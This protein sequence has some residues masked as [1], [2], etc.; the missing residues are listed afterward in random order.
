[1][2]IQWTGRYG[3][4]AEQ[5]AIWRAEKSQKR[6]DKK[7]PVPRRETGAA[8]QGSQ[9]RR[10]G[11]EGAGRRPHACTNAN[12]KQRVLHVGQMPKL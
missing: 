7:C 1:M 2:F 5:V 6:A 10:R 8:G 9:N 4:V 11:M 3:L 12:M